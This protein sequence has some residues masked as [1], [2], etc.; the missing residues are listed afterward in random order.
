MTD[1]NGRIFTRR[2][3]ALV[4][5]DDH[6]REILHG[7]KEGQ[8]VMVSVRKVRSARQHRLAWGLAQKLS[9][10]VDWLHD[11]ED[12]MDYLK[13]KARHV[14]YLI[15]PRTGEVTMVPKS[16]AYASCPQDTFNRLFNRMVWIICTEI[17]PGMNAADLRREVLA[18]VDGEPMKAAA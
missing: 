15:E 3:G 9:E 11:R 4:P 2:G 13:I 17:V 7:V 14:R 12:A 5:A 16:I 8:S 1:I 10:A 18:M 6:A